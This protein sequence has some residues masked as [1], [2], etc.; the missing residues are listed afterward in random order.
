[1]EILD[2]GVQTTSD[3][4]L[5]IDAY[6]RILALIMSNEIPP[7]ARINIDRLALRLEVSATPVREALTRL[8]DDGLV[9]KTHLK[10]YRT[11]A[12]LTA[13]QLDDLYGL[14]L[15]LEPASAATAAERG[16]DE[17][18]T[19]LQQELDSY[20]GTPAPDTAQSYARF[21]E[22]DARLHALIVRAAGNPAVSHALERTHFHLHAFRLSYDQPAAV[23]TSDEH[24]RIVAAIVARDADAASAAVREH[25]DASRKRF[26]PRAPVP[27]AAD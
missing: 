15:L 22:H 8:E 17:D 2:R 16:S 23:T 1:M 3:R 25:L 11:T 12:M 24:A 21:S 27:P 4:T 10:G 13:Q 20:V 19:A 7:D 14:R 5:G 18:I 9:A 26:L 6:E